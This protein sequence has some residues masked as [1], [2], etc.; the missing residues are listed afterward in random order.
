MNLTKDSFPIDNIILVKKDRLTA[1]LVAML[2]DAGAEIK[3]DSLIGKSLSM[4]KLPV[5]WTYD[6]QT[7]VA[8]HTDG[9]T[10]FF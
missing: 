8:T 6:K 1:T 2:Q 5:G 7:K 10:L 9:S 3:N 4:V